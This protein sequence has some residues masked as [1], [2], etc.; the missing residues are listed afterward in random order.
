VFVC[1]FVAASAAGDRVEAQLMFALRVTDSSDFIHVLFEG[2]EAETFLGATAA[3]I[4]SSPQVGDRVARRLQACRD[5]SL[6]CEFKV[7]VIVH[8]ETVVLPSSQLA[9]ANGA[10]SG[11]GGRRGRGAAG[12]AKEAQELSFVRYAQ[13]VVFHYCLL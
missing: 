13:R 4:M 1:S 5:L 10:S 3:E 2:A 9:G 7:K 11:G 8:K 12:R 6:P